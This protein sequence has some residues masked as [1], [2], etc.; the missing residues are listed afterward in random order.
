MEVHN[1]VIY[2]TPVQVSNPFKPAPGYLN[3]LK[4]KTTLKRL[5]TYRSKKLNYTNVGQKFADPNVIHC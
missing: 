2:K 3:T 4:N 5:L 1:N